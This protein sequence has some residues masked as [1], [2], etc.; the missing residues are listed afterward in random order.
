MNSWFT[1]AQDVRVW[2]VRGSQGQTV[3]R[4]SRSAAKTGNKIRKKKQKKLRKNYTLF[5]PVVAESAYP[6]FQGR[7]R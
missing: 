2:N 6:G 4:P 3:L 5:C 7:L 1:H